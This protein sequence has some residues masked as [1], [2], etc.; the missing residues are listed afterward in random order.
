MIDAKTGREL[1]PCPEDPQKPDRE[2][3]TLFLAWGTSGGVNGI[4]PRVGALYYGNPV[5][6][7]VIGIVPGQGGYLAI[8]A[9][10]HWAPFSRNPGLQLTAAGQEWATRQDWGTEATQG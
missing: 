9:A 10:T 2:G 5:K 7:T 4:P 8:F 3:Y 6:R 1:A